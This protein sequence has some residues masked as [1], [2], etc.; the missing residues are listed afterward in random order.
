MRASIFLYVAVAVAE[1][2]APAASVAQSPA[3]PSAS[4]LATQLVDMTLPTAL[5][6]RDTKASYIS[7]LRARFLQDPRAEA[8]VQ[9]MP[10]LLDAI[11]DAASS[12]FDEVFATMWPELKTRLSASY[13]ASM[14]AEE[15]AAAVQFY[16]AP[17][18]T[19]L[20]EATALIAKGRDIT[21]VLSPSELVSFSAFG[22]SPAGRKI[23]ALKAQQG[24]EIGETFNRAM[25]AGQPMIDEAA[26]LAARTFLAGHR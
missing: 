23:E 19:K 11:L 8:D 5:I 1:L 7:N 26:L 15:L 2:S 4:D 9:R 13:T 21:Q 16:S 18:G 12:K 22:R 14:S 3:S 20:V 25:I 24:R 17:V 10:G 6:Q